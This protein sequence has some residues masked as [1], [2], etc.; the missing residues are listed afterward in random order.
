MAKTWFVTGASSGIGRHLVETALEEGDAVVATV[1]KTGSLSDVQKKFADRLWIKTLDVTRPADV[2][3]VIRE[4]LA[5]R[6][7]IDVVVNNAGYG[8]IGATEEF[9][10]AEIQRQIATN[11]MAPIQIT[12]AFLK[13]MREE[14]GGHILQV[15]SVGGQVAYPVSSPYHAAKWGLEGFTESVSQEVAEFGVHFT[16]IEPGAVRTSFQANLQWTPKI[17]A[18]EDS[19]VGKMRNWLESADETLFTGDPRKVARAIFDTTRLPEPPLRLTLGTDAYEAI[20]GALQG[21]LALLES[22]KELAGTIA[23]SN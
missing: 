8:L 3:Q 6:G 4:S 16:L 10:D 17:Q 20:H 1:R 21:R 13:P 7:R 11:L 22:Q 15:S 19:A 9:S 14:G 12:R 23:F 18:Y 5:E 2:A